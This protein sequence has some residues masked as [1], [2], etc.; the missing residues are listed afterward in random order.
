MSSQ[1]SGSNR[2]SMC[3]RLQVGSRAP[4]KPRFSAEPPQFQ[5]T[6]WVSPA[7]SAQFQVIRKGFGVSRLGFG[8]DK[9]VKPD[10]ERMIRS[11]I[12]GAFSPRSPSC[13]SETLVL[14]SLHWLPV[15][16]RMDLQVLLLTERAL[17][18]PSPSNL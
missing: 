5:V 9:N 2:S 12:R 8:Q 10:P 3:E 14:V 18:G 11:R 1:D 6:F 13:C 15:K 4:I 16:F 17:S 7:S